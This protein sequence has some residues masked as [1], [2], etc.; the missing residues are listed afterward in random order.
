MDNNNKDT[1][2]KEINNEAGNI[3]EVICDRIAQLRKRDKLSQE[4]LANMLGIT[5]QAVSKWENNVSCPDISILPNIAK[6]FNVPIGWLF[7]EDAYNEELAD[8]QASSDNNGLNDGNIIYCDW[9]N[10][11]TVRVVVA[12]GHKLIKSQELNENI[13]QFV[14]VGLNTNI[15]GGKIESQLTI[16]IPQETEVS[17]SSFTAGANINCGDITDVGTMTA[18]ANINCGDITD[19][20]AITA[21]NSINSQD[22]TDGGTISAGSSINSGDISE[23][24]VVS[25]GNYIQCGDISEC[26]KVEAHGSINCGDISG[27]SNVAAKD[28]IICGDISDCGE[29]DFGKNN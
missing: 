24:G 25:A 27:C 15:D 2:S 29:I 4:A 23:A 13:K 5:F 8:R 11:D 21:G 20:G 3:S 18:G 28:K 14:S 6:V 26:D 19:G 1:V 9:E 22:I 12:R 10:D 7:G 16:C 17:N